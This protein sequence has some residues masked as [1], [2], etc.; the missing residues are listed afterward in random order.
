MLRL[1]RQGIILSL[2]I[3]G[4]NI[5]LYLI[6]LAAACLNIVEASVNFIILNVL[7][8][9]PGL[10][11]E[12]K[13][14][15]VQLDAQ[16]IFEQQ[17]QQEQNSA[18]MISAHHHSSLTVHAYMAMN[19]PKQIRPFPAINAGSTNFPRTD[20]GAGAGSGVGALTSMFSSPLSPHHSSAP[21]QQQQRRD[22][23][24]QFPHHQ[25]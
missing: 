11:K 3:N 17:L 12:Q 8:A 13:H 16:R 19:S 7:A 6:V 25:D 14:F 24:L 1:G 5:S 10:R 22:R 2:F 4:L 18:R 21:G 15:R 20:T 9:K 23:E